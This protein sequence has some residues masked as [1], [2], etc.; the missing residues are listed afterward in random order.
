MAEDRNARARAEHMTGQARAVRQQFAQAFA[1][2]QV[3]VKDRFGRNLRVNDLVVYAPTQPLVY[4]VVAIDAVLDPNAP[5]GLIRVILNIDIPV[6]WQAGLAA[7]EMIVVGM[8][9][10]TGHSEINAT[11]PSDGPDQPLPAASE[12]S[13][14]DPTTNE[15]DPA[16]GGP[17]Q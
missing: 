16:G 8:V 12:A 1:S 6:T 3:H 5:P 9:K 13:A 10:E 2:G 7:P 14:D 11:R 4:Q 15:D 17:I